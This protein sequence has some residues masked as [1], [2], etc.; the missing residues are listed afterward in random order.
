MLAP[1][2]YSFVLGSGVILV[3]LAV[4][5][6]MALWMEV[7]TQRSREVQP[8]EAIVSL[9]LLVQAMPA[10]PEPAA[11]ASCEAP[12]HEH[13]GHDH[14]HDHDHAHGHGDAH[15]HHE[16]DAPGHDHDHDHS[17][18]P[19]RYVL[20]LV[21]VILF[22]LGIPNEP[23]PVKAVTPEV[24]HS[25]EASFTTSWIAMA[26]MPSPWM[27]AG[28]LLSGAMSRPAGEAQALDFQTL[29][30]SA[31]KVEFRKMWAGRF[32]RVIGQYVPNR[33]PANDRVFS[34]GRFRINCCRQDAVALNVPIIA[35]EA[36][37]NIKANDWIQVTGEIQY[38]LDERGLY[39]T[40]LMV[41]SKDDV[42]K[43]APD[44]DP[45]IR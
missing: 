41:H 43:T 9:P 15:H 19:W 26:A 45:Y 4:L 17:W 27:Q 32:V 33:N 1:Q 44:P 18:A 40:Q 28:K 29:E 38:R 24:D 23:P 30:D 12:D 7:R 8:A 37:R 10:A 16:H 5:R 36:I 25:R 34:L 31:S 3:L 39:H 35:S 11:T 2:F 14:D 13:C 21:P 20:L 22:F 6:G 42:V